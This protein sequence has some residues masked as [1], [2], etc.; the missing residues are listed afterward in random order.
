MQLQVEDIQGNLL[1]GYGKMPYASFLLLSIENVRQTREW[2]RTLDVRSGS[3][4]SEGLETCSN[5][6]TSS[7][8]IEKLGLAKYAVDMFAGEFREGMTATNH[9]RRI[10]GDTGDSSPDQW[11]WGGPGNPPV[12]LL[13]MCYATTEA[14]IR[15][16]VGSH[17]AR[18]E[19]C[20]L[21]LV[22]RL[23]SSVIPDGK[24]HFG[25][26]D[27][28]AQ[29]AIDGFHDGALKHNTV[30]AGEFI[31]GYRN[32]YGQLTDRPLLRREDDPHDVLAP[33]EDDEQLRD[34]GRNGSYLVFRQLGQDVQGFWRYIDANVK[35]AEGE[36]KAAARIRLASK[37]MGRWPNGGP[38][39]KPE[40]TGD[41]P[42]SRDNDFLY[43]RNNDQE[44]HRCPIGAHIRRTNPRDALD[45]KPGSDRSIEIGKRHR[46]IRRG[47]P[48]GPPVAQSVDPADILAA[49]DGADHERGLH[50]LCFN[51]H[52]G[53]QF[54][55]IQHTWVNNPKFDGLYDDDDPIIGSRGEGGGPTA[56]GFTIQDEIRERYSNV[57]RFVHVKGGAYFFMPGIRALRY[58]ASLNGVEQ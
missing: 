17:E 21:R 10:L 27:G 16:V 24:E 33:V 15:D 20:G 36:S 35:P 1:R 30:A 22:K 40:Y 57:P 13:F 3:S 6:A 25:F 48:Y 50:F 38:L 8:G 46:I 32:A 41:S 29:P 9:R 53:R 55:F 34:F 7:A 44:G 2:L 23:E 43:V 11:Q 19:A 58:L 52:I 18:L 37:M 45:P 5:I 54:E 12:D 49:T 42:D 56:G 26:K 28:I 31:L 51:T 14:G 39:V 4:L 47:R